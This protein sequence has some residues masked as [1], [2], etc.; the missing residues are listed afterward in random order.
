[1]DKHMHFLVTRIMDNC[2]SLYPI[3]R[4]HWRSWTLPSACLRM[5]VLYLSRSCTSS[6]C[7]RRCNKV[8]TP[9]IVAWWWRPVMKVVGIVC[10]AFVVEWHCSVYIDEAILHTRSEYFINSRMMFF[11]TFTRGGKIIMESL[12]DSMLERWLETERKKLI[13]K[14]IGKGQSDANVERLWRKGW[15][16]NIFGWRKMRPSGHRKKL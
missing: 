16:L 4:Y 15:C 2:H 11:Y 5:W 12:K 3:P 13:F 14:L 10:K 1:M 9:Y 8:V 7:R 6:I